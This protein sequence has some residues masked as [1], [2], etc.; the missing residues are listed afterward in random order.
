M[1]HPKSN[2]AIS[3]TV[4]V[5]L[6]LLSVQLVW[7]FPKPLFFFYV[8]S[9]VV[10]SALFWYLKRNS[11]TRGLLQSYQVVLVWVIFTSIFLT[12]V[13]KVDRGGWNW[14]RVTGYNVTLPEKHFDM[15]SASTA[16]FLSRYP[17]FEMDAD[18]MEFVLRKGTYEIDET[19]VVPRHH[20]L[21]I[22]AGATLLFE[23]GRSFISYSRIRALGTK[24]E[25][26]V[27]MPKNKLFKWGAVGLVR[28]E[29][30]IFENTIFRHA[31]Q[32]R[33]NDIDFLGG[34]SVIESDVEI[35]Q[36][37]FVNMFGK[38]ALN[39]QRANVTITNS[40]FKNALRD[41]LDLDGASGDVS[42]N[43]FINCQDEGI[44][45]SENFDDLRVFNNYIFDDRGGKIGAEN[46]INEILS[47]NRLGYL[48]PN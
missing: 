33:V 48:K 18:S 7:K 38:D 27:F 9:F 5:L 35:H 1:S 36:S 21:R 22:E 29:K 42:S 45:L 3:T 4:W 37:K 44:D 40:L 41:G 17:Y 26:V 8:G 43:Q 39:V 31:R 6:I 25:P 32:A 13:Y 19:I 23:T 46:N 47:L 12:G 2:I 34:L 20:P 28:T 15:V 30:S 11:T 24:E 10:L 14:Q 16:D